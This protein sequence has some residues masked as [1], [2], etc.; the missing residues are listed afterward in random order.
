VSDHG[1]ARRSK[2][3]NDCRITIACSLFSHVL[4]NLEHGKYID[5]FPRVTLLRG[6]LSGS[7]WIGIV[8]TDCMSGA[9]Y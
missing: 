6:V 2:T 8:L 3:V 5:I 7:F 4:E 9:P 1:L